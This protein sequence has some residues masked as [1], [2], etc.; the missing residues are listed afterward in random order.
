M[1]RILLAL[2]PALACA[3]V[4]AAACAGSSAPQPGKIAASGAT[5]DPAVRAA[6][7]AAAAAAT[8]AVAAT[9]AATA[10]ATTPA[11]ATATPPAAAAGAA[12]ATAPAPLPPGV[13][14]R[15]AG[16]QGV[17]EVLE[18]EGLR[19]LVI[20]GAV[21]AAVP[22]GGAP[23]PRDALVGVLRQVRPQ[24]KTALV[25]GL[26]SGATATQLAGLGLDVLAIELEPKVIELARRFFGFRGKAEP[27]DG[28]EVLRRDPRRWDVIVVD[29]L[30]PVGLPAP[31][32]EPA[33]IAV[34]REHLA[35]DGGVLAVRMVE[36]PGSAA[37]AAF[38]ARAREHRSH[39]ALGSGVGDERQN[40]YLLDSD[41]PLSLA[42][43]PA[44]PVWPLIVPGYTGQRVPASRDV[45]VLGYLVRVGP[46]RK[47][48]LDLL[49]W[50]MGAVRFVLGGTPAAALEK[51]APPRE[52]PSSGDIGTDG[53]LRNTLADSLGGAHF[54][55]SDI[56]YSP[57]IV[58]LR[59]TAAFREAIHAD[60]L[61]RIRGAGRTA[62]LPWGGVLYDLDVASVEWKLELPAWRA[63]RRAKLAPAVQRLH[64]AARAGNLRGAH[65]AAKEYVAALEAALGPWAPEFE[66]HRQMRF[67]QSM[68]LGEDA[69]PT[70]AEACARAAGAIDQ[71][72]REGYFQNP[73]VDPLAGLFR[74]CAKP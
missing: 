33:A 42:A 12:K 24:A 50:E 31:F 2:A 40:L 62:L 47:L 48:C 63:L 66:V 5:A 68:L 3:V 14:A 30:A 32:L 13:L 52:S 53:D 17:I 73:D 60:D 43:D 6:P 23:A 18:R 29:A 64:A 61:E 45:T 26:G 49:H 15:E 46:E 69:K 56:R 27:G 21:H 1:R 58:A 25:I 7:A 71:L 34:M 35:P 19:Q 4:C 44:L 72:P 9:A 20:G 36:A 55:R 51:L 39:L 28:L 54:K 22:L 67:V 59:G 41:R 8:G 57:T 38:L 70:R 74:L 16:A 37:A 10:T 11:A 65:A